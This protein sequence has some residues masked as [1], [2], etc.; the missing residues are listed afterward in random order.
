MSVNE[1]V[2]P[3]S[4]FLAVLILLKLGFAALPSAVLSGE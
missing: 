1:N 4:M 3:A 2:L